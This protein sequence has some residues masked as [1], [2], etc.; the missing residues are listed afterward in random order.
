MWGTQQTV[1]K[2]LKEMGTPDHLTCH[3]RK[4][5]ADQAK[6]V[7]TQSGTT[8]WFQIEKGLQQGYI[9]IYIYI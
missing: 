8:G 5:C 2:I 4:L 6:A 1:W 3:L 9:Y 7:R